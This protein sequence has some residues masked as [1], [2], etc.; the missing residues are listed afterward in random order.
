MLL[1]AI[2]GS[3]ANAA[4]PKPDPKELPRLKPLEPNETLKS[5]RVREGFKLQL[6][7]SEP[8]VAD[9]MAIAFD[10]EGRMYVV[11]LHGYPEKRHEALGK[12]KRLTDV[13]GDGV[14]D[15]VT[16]FAE[17]LKWP[18]AVL[19]YDGG[20]FIGCAPDILFMRDHD[21]DGV[22]EEKKVVFT[23]FGAGSPREIAPRLFNSFRWGLDNRIHA[24]SSMN[25]GIVRRPDQQE[26]EALDL[27]RHD[28][29]FDPRT[30]DLRKE[31]GSAQHG[32]SFN[33]RGQKFLSRNSNHIMSMVYDW[34]YAERNKSYSMPH[35]RVDIAREGPAAKIFRIS[36]DEPWRVLRTRWRVSGEIRGSVEGG[37]TAFGYFTSATGV[38]I[39]RGNAF[40]TRYLGNAFIGAP[41]NNLVHRKVFEPNTVQPVAMRDKD[42]QDRE[43]IASTDNWFR[44]VQFSNAPDGTLYVVDMYR[45]LIE[46]AH[47]IPDSIKAHMDIY[48]GTDRGRIY[49]VLPDGFEQPAGPGLKKM[50]N[51]Q[52]AIML[53]HRSGWHQDTASRLLFE[54]ND[55][56]VVPELVQLLETC[57]GGFSGRIR[58]LYLLRHFGALNAG[59]LSTAFKDK[60]AG[61]REHAV[62]LAETMDLP[63]LDDQLSAL[64]DDPDARVRFQLAL[65][66]GSMKT[67][68]RSSALARLAAG[69][70]DPWIQAAILSSLAGAEIEVFRE[71]ARNAA[72]D[73]TSFLIELIKLMG[74]SGHGADEVV[75]LVL[76]QQQ[77]PTALVYLNALGEGLRRSKTPTQSL[78][79]SGGLERFYSAAKELSVNQREAVENRV[80]AIETLGQLKY[81]DVG[82]RLLGLLSVK[83]P[84][85]VQLA[86]LDS[87][88]SFSVEDIARE[89]V[90]R[91]SI[92]TPA[93]R[94]RAM[95]MFLRRSA[96]SMIMLAAVEEGMMTLSD[97]PTTRHRYLRNHGNKS[98]RAKSVKVLGSQS[99]SSRAEV[100]KRFMP[101]LNRNGRSDAGAKSFAS[102]CVTC[103]RF[104]GQGHQLGPDLETT[105]R[106]SGEELLTHILDPNR[107]VDPTQRAYAVETTDGE[108]FLGLVVSETEG[109]VVLKMPLGQVANI[110]RDRV[111]SLKGQGVSIMPEGL[112]LEMSTQEMADLIAYLKE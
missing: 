18:S 74:A 26:S 50:S 47:A 21:G 104:K 54:R 91:W 112:E 66:L 73:S 110:P 61:V 25:A 92:F 34:R 108:S 63:E 76:D 81:G 37:G 2:A 30:L 35:W 111:R 23:G 64:V 44:P 48:S 109:S 49:R 89:L 24:A 83:E 69:E 107:K 9:P 99:K 17:G 45:E 10:A 62:K 78:G 13:D 52:L 70:S 85:P 86:A 98:V 82:T 101:A 71:L 53:V 39:Y 67:K 29:S 102:R 79:G 4:D 15:K 32:L 46:V 68:A 6:V 100:I 90:N 27:R 75:K 57:Q 1:L 94:S 16:T 3:S 55:A 51:K 103:H 8:M 38:T 14:F 96:Y 12:V 80:I 77:A 5:F 87:L 97:I 95:R 36:P 93:V 40:P 22:A 106:W 31:S 88:D 59:H 33:R 11:E 7:A 65:S 72:S 20:V 58:I 56:G 41:A 105:K 28:F 43:F 19:C 42:E 60:A 84:E